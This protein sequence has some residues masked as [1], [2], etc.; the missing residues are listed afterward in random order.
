MARS[1]L[2]L[3]GVFLGARI[4]LDTYY[5]RYWTDLV[6]KCQ[7]PDYDNYSWETLINIHNLIYI[8]E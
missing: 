2:S 1:F 4:G 3:E 6:Q 7:F 8:R 5:I